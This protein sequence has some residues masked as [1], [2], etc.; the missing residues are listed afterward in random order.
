[1]DLALE[2]GERSLLFSERVGGTDLLLVGN[3]SAGEI[4]QTLGN[5]PKARTFLMRAV[6][7]IE[8]EREQEH[9]GQ[10]GLPAVRARSHLAWTLAELGDFPGARMGADEAMGIADVSN[11][12]YTV[13]HACLGLGGTRVRQGEFDAAI[14]VLAR[15]FATS[16][17]VPLLRPPIAADLGLSYA[18][19]GR[20]AEGLSHL[21]AAVEGAT[22]MGRFSRLPLLLAKCG[23]IHLLA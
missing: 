13:C 22:K 17:S 4:Y 19:W 6:L 23:E 20:I 21:D 1:S 7:L 15:G 8:P 11:H 3:M 12:P 9:A 5:Y 18:R 14:A 16:E 2:A 10:V